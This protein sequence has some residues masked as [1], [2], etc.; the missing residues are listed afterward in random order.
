MTGTGST[1]A[2]SVRSE[3]GS[4]MGPFNFPH[5]TLHLEGVNCFVMKITD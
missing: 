5:S 2:H 4:R 3:P 1:V